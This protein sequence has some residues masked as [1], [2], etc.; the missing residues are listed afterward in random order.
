MQALAK[1]ST[2]CTLSEAS[3]SVMQALSVMTAIKV[4][5]LQHCERVEELDVSSN[6]LAQVPA[7][8]AN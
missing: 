7:R 8:V 2:K 1:L 6:G 3:T 4:A 5:P